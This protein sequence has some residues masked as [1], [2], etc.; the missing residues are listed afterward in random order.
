MITLDL[1]SVE[2]YDENTNQ[3]VED[4]GGIVRFEYSLKALYNWE[5]KW[6]KPFF[7]GNLT[8]A[9]TLDFYKMM[10]LDPVEDRFLTDAVQK[11]LADYIADDNTATTFSSDKNGQNGNQTA[12]KGKFDTSEEI[13][14]KMFQAQ[15]PLEFENRHLGRLMVMLRI[16]ATYNSP[17]KKMTKNDIFRTNAELNRQRKAEMKTRG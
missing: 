17:P 10:A 8:D 14:A 13:Y 9:E 6:K 7:K 11:V 15:V 3:F 16:I 12:N 1:G 4:K 2:Y 5:G